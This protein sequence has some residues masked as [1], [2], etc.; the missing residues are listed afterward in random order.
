[1]AV[2]PA[3]IAAIKKEIGELPA[4]IRKRFVDEYGFS[5]THAK[6]FSSDADLAEYTEQVI[7][8]LKNWLTSIDPDATSEEIWEKNGR[9]YD[10]FRPVVEPEGF[11]SKEEL[12]LSRVYRFLAAASAGGEQSRQA[13][14]VV[15]EPG[16]GKTEGKTQPVGHSRPPIS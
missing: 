7:S 2:K 1:M 16:T 5:A 13:L 11:C 8:E 15:G 6:T 14:V 12:M 4:D 10:P 9:F 3:I